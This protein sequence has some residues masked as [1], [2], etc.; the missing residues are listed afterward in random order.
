M[1]ASVTH[2]EFNTT[3]LSNMPLER[4]DG[5]MSIFAP[6]PP[7]RTSLCAWT[8]D[9]FERARRMTSCGV[10]IEFYMPKGFANV[11]RIPELADVQLKIIEFEESW[12]GPSLPPNRLQVALVLVSTSVRW[13]TAV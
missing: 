12:C 10:P 1:Q 9:V 4:Q 5:C 11:Y 3:V 8:F 6:T 13:R 2:P 7:L